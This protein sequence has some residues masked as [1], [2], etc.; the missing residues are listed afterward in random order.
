MRKRK[1]PVATLIGGFFIALVTLVGCGA[2]TPKSIVIVSENSV[3]SIRADET[4]QLSASV[5]PDNA[6]QEVIW[7]SSKP[8]VAS[9]SELGLITPISFD[10]RGVTFTATSKSYPSVKEE[11]DIMISAATSD[12]SSLRSAAV[13]SE[14]TIS[15]VVSNYVYTG[16][17]T[18]YITGMFVTD[19][20]GSLYVFGE[21]TAKSVSLYNFVVLKGRKTYY[22]P[23]TD[24]GS[25]PAVNY[26]GALQLT[27]PEIIYNDNKTTNAIPE[28]GVTT[29]YSL[30]SIINT[31]LSTDITGNL[32][33]LKAR[34]RKVPGSGFTNYYIDDLNRLDTILCYTQSNGKDFAYLD[35]Y[36][37]EVV[38]IL[39]NI[40]LGKPGTNSWRLYPSNIITSTL[41]SAE[42]EAKYALERAI[43][44]FPAAYGDSVEVSFS[45]T[46]SLLEGVTRSISSTSDHV[47]IV[48]NTNDYTINFTVDTT[49]TCDLSITATYQEISKTDTVTITLGGKP[50]YTAISLADAKKKS[51][52]E[53]VTVDAI[54]T[55]LVYKSGTDTPAGAFIAD[56]TDSFFAYNG[57]EY[58]DTLAEVVEGNKIAFS[59]TITHYISNADNASA[60]S[61][62]GDF[63][64]ADITLIYNDQAIHDIPATSISESSVQAISETAGSTNISGNTY[65]V[66]GKITKTS[67][68]YYSTYYLKDTTGTYS[69]NVYSQKNGSD[70]T[71]L[72]PYVNTDVTLY[73]GVQNAKYSASSLT[74]RVCP[75]SIIA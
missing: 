52:G 49:T 51:D 42:D 63:Q 40:I 28:G 57:A 62:T 48:E 20:T 73:V 15:G 39:A 36:D 70:F 11:I 60:N 30:S 35:S 33:R 31:P 41:V 24:S 14:Y 50:S 29:L 72:E 59:G 25:A 32:Y 6:S 13:D 66:T 38:L 4:L 16:Q 12:I 10:Y 61:Y 7:E 8:E 27:S 69:L 68:T 3:T 47:S 55:R 21:N 74:W 65:K 2:S 44:E 46:D 64:I 5:Y 22:I 71:W 23:E 17:G 43:K 19:N 26:V 1:V 75:I 56:E 34:I 18:P 45:K 9:I 37:G 67:S 58:L 54:V 53:T